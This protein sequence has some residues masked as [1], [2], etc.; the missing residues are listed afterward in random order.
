[1]QGLQQWAVR[2]L[3]SQQFNYAVTCLMF[4]SPPPVTLLL[5]PYIILAV[6][7]AMAHAAAR[8][9]GHP[10]WR[11]RGAPLWTYLQANRAKALA[12][13]AQFEVSLG[14][15]MVFLC[16]TP[17]RALLVTFFVV[18]WG[19]ASPPGWLCGRACRSRRWSTVKHL[20]KPRAERTPLLLSA[21]PPPTHPPTHPPAV[22]AAE[23]ALLVVRR[24]PPPPR[25]VGGPR[26]GD[27]G[28]PRRGAVFE[29]ADRFHGQVVPA[30]APDERGAA[31]GAAAVTRGRAWCRGARLCIDFFFDECE[32]TLSVDTAH[33]CSVLHTTTVFDDCT[34]KKESRVGTHSNLLAGREASS[35]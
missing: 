6:Y 14:F 34:S 28:D 25:G 18:S 26:R 2:A 27:Q 19:G 9:S 29:H 17:N 3:P 8:Y 31:A 35:L 4:L 11:E 32:Y 5:L 20:A 21:T 7:G 15:Y 23:A 10:L 24:R 1:M 12:L 16:F 22:A 33:Q 30:G 13:N